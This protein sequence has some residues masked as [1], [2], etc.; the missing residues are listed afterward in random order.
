MWDGG[1]GVCRTS[2]GRTLDQWKKEVVARC[3]GNAVPLTAV[4]TMLAS[5]AIPFLDRAAE[6][7]TMVHFYGN[8]SQGKTTSL[9]A[10]ASVWGC[11]AAVT[12][13]QSFMHSWRMTANASENLLDAHSGIGICL[14]E[15]ASFD[16]KSAASFAYDFAAGRGK[17]RMQDNTSSREQR[18][19]Q[20][21]ALSS[22]EK[23]LADHAQEARVGGR[24]KV[25]EG[26]AAA[27]IINVPVGQ[28]FTDVHGEP[29]AKE[30]AE[31][32]GTASA[33]FYGTAGPAFVEWLIAHQD[34]AR[35]RLA[36]LRKAWDAHALLVVPPGA[37]EQAR[38]V[39]S[40]LGAIAA[41]AALASDVL[42]L[43]IAAPSS[44]G[45]G[46]A[47]PSEAMFWAFSDVLAAWLA[48][49]GTSAV[50]TEVGELFRDLI[51]GFHRYPGRFQHA[52]RGQSGDAD[53]GP[54]PTERLGWIISDQNNVWLFVDVLPGMLTGTLGWND[55]Q[56][57]RVA[58][59]LAKSGF[60]GR[61]NG[62]GLLTYAQRSDGSRPGVYRI[63]P[64]FFEQ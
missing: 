35:V 9:R 15:L 58:E 47:A 17:A 24:R 36:A 2:K 41:C 32:L 12:S 19:W 54:P 38:R 18:G 23:T 13:P 33:T 55:T 44:A 11:G 56:K 25:M 5:P 57:D 37:A 53:A 30:F 3:N 48:K 26:G 39:A 29:D 27:R 45:A 63:T 16:A 31:K 34:E 20:L 49:T 64:A 6:A 14:D 21:F 7:N 52:T 28:I 22:G 10:A 50:S 42:D 61:G 43:P 8:T 40:R 4:G 62:R 59:A 1:G 51:D 46:L 60:L